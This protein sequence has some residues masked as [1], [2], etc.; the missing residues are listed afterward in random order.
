[1]TILEA[2]DVAVKG[3][4]SSNADKFKSLEAFLSRRG[5]RQSATNKELQAFY[6]LNACG[7]ELP[8]Y[9]ADGK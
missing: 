5:N 2:W 7:L 8:L 6:I 1:M 9:I 4:R 3:F